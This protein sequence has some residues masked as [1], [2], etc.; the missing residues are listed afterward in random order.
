M[1]ENRVRS[2]EPNMYIHIHVHF[3]NK[4]RY[5]SSFNTNIIL[6]NTITD[7]KVTFCIK[8]K[9]VDPDENNTILSHLTRFTKSEKRI[10]TEDKL[11]RAQDSQ[12]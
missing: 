10:K 5:H 7:K 9:A 1:R 4:N 12:T 8:K 3:A 11:K 2:F 6:E